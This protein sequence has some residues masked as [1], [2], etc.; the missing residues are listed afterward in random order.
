MWQL[1][2]RLAS[3]H[4][5]RTIGISMGVN[6]VGWVAAS[7]LHT[8]KFHDFTGGLTFILLSSISHGQ[9]SSV[10]WGTQYPV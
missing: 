8:E 5:V 10:F 1:V 3:K 9:S 6:W 7:V 4:L 2:T